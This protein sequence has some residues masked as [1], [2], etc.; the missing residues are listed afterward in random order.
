VLKVESSKKLDPTHE[1]L[2]NFLHVI[3]KNGLL[4]IENLTLMVYF[5][6]LRIWDFASMLGLVGMSG[7]L[8]IEAPCDPALSHPMKA[9]WNNI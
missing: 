8:G 5:L 9:L 6:R 3:I 1:F 2:R 4:W 7:N